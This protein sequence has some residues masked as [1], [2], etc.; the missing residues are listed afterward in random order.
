MIDIHI[1]TRDRPTELFGLLESIREQSS[2]EKFNIVIL[3]DGGGTP[4]AN[5][6]FLQYMFNRLKCE[7]H[8]V[9]IIRNEIASGVSKAR[10]TLVDWSL[11]NSKSKLF[12]RID[13][14]SI[15]ECDYIFK[16]L[17]VIDNG[18]DVASGIVPHFGSPETIR[19]IKFVEP[20]IGY[21]ELNDKGEL[22]A[23]YDDCST[24]F[25]EEKILPSPHFRSCALFKREIFENGIDYNS[26]LSKNGFREEQ[27]LSFKIIS[28]GYKIGI[29]TGA[30]A[31]HLATPSGGERDTMNL[32]AFNQQIFDE[33]TKRIFEEKG[34]FIKS[35]YNN[36]GVIPIKKT[37][38]EL[39]KSINLVN[40]KE[41]IKLL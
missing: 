28:K 1:A 27:I 11:K 15:L 25:T 4:I 34:D 17:K 3:D 9:V 31:W 2:A 16:L 14:D 18:Y 5:Y 24:H 20:V 26:R 32:G 8:N 6:Y 12:A 38:G 33:T 37:N 22:I 7:G 13:D 36:L 21:C 35:Y 30:I 39:L 40:K 19:D 41:D 29:H 10:Q 23:N